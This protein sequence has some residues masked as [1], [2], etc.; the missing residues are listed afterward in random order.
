MDITSCCQK[1]L[2]EVNLMLE[3]L[4]YNA[5][6]PFS[7]QKEWEE[8]NQLK[9]KHG[10]QVKE[11]SEELLIYHFRSKYRMTPKQVVQNYIKETNKLA[12]EGG[13]GYK[14]YYKGIKDVSK[15][16]SFGSYGCPYNWIIKPENYELAKPT[17]DQLMAL[18]Y[19]AR[20]KEHF[21]CLLSDHAE[22]L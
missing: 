17:T 15:S 19:Y 12:Q 16:G 14:F 4:G 7:K 18:H 10:Q 22:E 21:R 8:L 3:T 1:S 9:I 2:L 13:Y 11:D 5:E 6:E 20:K